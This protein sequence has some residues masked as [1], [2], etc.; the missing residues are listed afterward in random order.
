MTACQL[1]H[2][3]ERHTA[4]SLVL[5]SMLAARPIAPRQKDGK[6]ISRP[7][8][9]TKRKDRNTDIVRVPPD[10]LTAMLIVYKPQL[11]AQS[12]QFHICLF[13][14]NG[15]QKDCKMFDESLQQEKKNNKTKQIEKRNLED[16]QT[17]QGIE[18]I[19]FQQYHIV[20]KDSPVK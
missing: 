8:S 6:Y 18:K 14:K 17:I 20:F 13:F 10:R 5:L 12:F 19:I 11:H 9:Q 3:P 4:S 15:Q 1:L 7:I 2:E 16:T